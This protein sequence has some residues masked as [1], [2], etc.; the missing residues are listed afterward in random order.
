MPNR[1]Q[2]TILV[3]NTTERTDLGVE[4]GLSL[5]IDYRDHKVLLDAGQSGLVAQNAQTLGIDLSQ[6]DILVLSHGHYDHTGGAPAVLKL[7][8]EASVCMHSKACWGRY[9]RRPDGMHYIGM[10]RRSRQ[11][12]NKH[13]KVFTDTPTVITP[14]IGVTGGIP[15]NCP[16]E[17]PEIKFSLNINGSK[18]DS[19]LDDQAVFIKTDLGL[20]VLL[21]C[22]HAGVVNT[23]DYIDKVSNNKPI[24]AVIGGMHLESANQEKL[25]QTIT[26]LLKRDIKQIIPLHCTGERAVA[27]MQESMPDRVRICHCGDTITFE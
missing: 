1:L 13:W 24:H 5:W 17:K 8:P 2:I 10:P 22:A 6:T 23:L 14:G 20:V 27:A 9:S 26:E 4:H 3:E 11:I 18:P 16:F 25:D 19:V 7:A 12:I 21:G 15:R